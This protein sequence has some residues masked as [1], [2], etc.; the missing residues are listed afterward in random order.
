[1]Q[2][3]YKYSRLCIE[4]LQLP[5]EVTSSELLEDS[6]PTLSAS[7]TI[8]SSCTGSTLTEKHNTN[9]VASVRT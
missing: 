4:S 3:L 8:S 7:A 2:H 1:M 9:K 5:K 6:L